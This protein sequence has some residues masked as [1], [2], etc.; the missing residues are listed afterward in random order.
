MKALGIMGSPRKGGN[1]DIIM[2]RVL[3]GIQ[4]NGGTVEKIILQDINIGFCQGCWL[5]Q[6]KNERCE[7]LRDGMD[8]LYELIISSDCII[9]G[10]PVYWFGVSAQLKVFIDRLMPFLNVNTYESKLEGKMGGII[11]VCANPDTINISKLAIGMIK[12]TYRLFKMK[13]IGEIAASARNK[14]DIKNNN[15]ILEEAYMLGKSIKL[16]S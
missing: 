13:L 6:K 10:T 3:E 14:G 5:C 11:T 9:L 4:E 16:S 7:V 15:K 1:T 12:R 8:R 2:D